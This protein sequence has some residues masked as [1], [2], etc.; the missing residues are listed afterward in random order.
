MLEGYDKI[1]PGSA[2][3]IMASADTQATHR[4]TLERLVV[5]SN[6]ARSARGQVFGLVIGA[7]GL[8]CAAAVGIWGDWRAAATIGAFPITGLVIVFVK[9]ADSQRE[10]RE[11]KA[12]RVLEEMGRQSAEPAE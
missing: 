12:R 11:V 3:K 4:Q 2:A 10:E 8:I 5:E 7:V 1:V 9:G 6:N